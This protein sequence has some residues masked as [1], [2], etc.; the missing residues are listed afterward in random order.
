M[1][2]VPWISS[3]LAGVLAFVW[4]EPCPFEDQVCIDIRTCFDLG[5]AEGWNG[6]IADGSVIGSGL[7]GTGVPG[8]I[9]GFTF[10]G[11]ACD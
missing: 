8:G 9:D 5:P 3:W 7:T 2:R 1:A 4:D 10:N 6:N 11:V